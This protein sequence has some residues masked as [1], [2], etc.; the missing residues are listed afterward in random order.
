MRPPTGVIHRPPTFLT[1]LLLFCRS[2]FK[3]ISTLPWLQ[4]LIAGGAG[5]LEAK[6]TLH[7][8]LILRQTRP[9]TPGTMSYVYKLLTQTINFHISIYFIDKW[10]IF[11]EVLSR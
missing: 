7:I 4:V 5:M 6:L 3:F 11:G 2:L 8:K 10:P 1:S 9:G